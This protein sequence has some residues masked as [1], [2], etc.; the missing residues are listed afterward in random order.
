MHVV[1]HAVRSCV[2]TKKSE[3]F[4][5]KRKMILKTWE[6]THK[7]TFMNWVPQCAGN[8]F[9]DTSLMMHVV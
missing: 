5:N 8:R 9:N 7:T 6:A 4:N 1:V 3:K 2:K